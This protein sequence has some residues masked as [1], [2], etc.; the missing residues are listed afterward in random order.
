MIY[1]IPP[2]L[3]LLFLTIQ[4]SV[5]EAQQCNSWDYK[6]PNQ[7][8]PKCWPTCDINKYPLQ[9]PVDIYN[10]WI[11]PTLGP[12][13]FQFPDVNRA[14]LIHSEH[15]V[16]VV[17]PP[18]YTGGFSV[19]GMNYRLQEF[20]FHTP[21]ENSLSVFGDGLGELDMEIHMVHKS[22]NS[23]NGTQTAILSLLWQKVDDY[24]HPWLNQILQNL[25]SIP[26]QNLSTSISLTDISSLFKDQQKDFG[27]WILEGTLTTPPCLGAITWYI[28]Q[29]PLKCSKA[30]WRQFHD[31]S[32][33]NARPNQRKIVARAYVVPK[34]TPPSLV[35]VGLV[36]S[37]V[38]IMSIILS[39]V[40][41]YWHKKRRD[42]LDISRPAYDR[43]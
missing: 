7:D 3:L 11:D 30:Q 10:E 36:V 18:D 22:Y 33:D 5:A 31:L 8:W 19:N 43:L 2:V 23:T 12:A 32:G 16:S 37:L 25:S 42:R 35:M 29:V 28:M 24:A 41:L 1:P 38:V 27:Y 26:N 39:A 6:N 13:V 4:I 9:D 15:T 20:H 17:Y 40:A 14:T 34:G 21:A